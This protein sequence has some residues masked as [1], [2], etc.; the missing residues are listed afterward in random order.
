M[1]SRHHGWLISKAE[2]QVAAQEKWTSQFLFST[3][4]D[5]ESSSCHVASS[6]P[7][8]RKPWSCFKEVRFPWGRPLDCFI[9]KICCCSLGCG[10]WNQFS[11][12]SSLVHTRL[13]DYCFNVFYSIVPQFSFPIGRQ[14]SVFVIIH[15]VNTY[16]IHAYYVSISRT[17]DTSV[18]KTHF[19]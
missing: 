19:F 13:Q 9:G 1:L 7:L 5:P 6:R 16:C 18:T 3:R 17:R 4:N 15:L 10:E 8:T 2:S 12:S 14:S 11:A